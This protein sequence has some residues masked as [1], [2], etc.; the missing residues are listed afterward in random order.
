VN[1]VRGF[2]M[3]NI[4][5]KKKKLSSY[6]IDEIKGMVREG[7]FREGDKL[8][9]QVEFAS[10]LGV[11]R[12]SLRE[13][14]N[15]L[16]ELG[17][18]QQKPGLGTVILSSNPDLWG[19]SPAPPLITD[20]SATIELVEAREYIEGSIAELAANGIGNDQL[21]V[22]EKDVKQMEKA[23]KKREIEEYRKYDMSFHLHIAYS[24]HNRYLVH[25][26][27]TICNLMD[28]FMSEVFAELP[29]LIPSSFE[30]HMHILE[31]IK[32]RDPKLTVRCMKKHISDVRKALE[33][34]YCSRGLLD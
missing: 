29:E 22:L 4:I 1:Q 24:S 5:S 23:L 33:N 25:M 13:A 28:R 11:S 2:D 27:I 21:H 9:N 7:R 30:H 16:S 6:I 17:V 14:L 10:Q 34:Y 15:T 8:P 26:Y 18:I 12:L 31:S 3:R 20:V 19:Q 32:K